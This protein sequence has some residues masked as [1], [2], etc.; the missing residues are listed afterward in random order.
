[1]RLPGLP[2]THGAEPVFYQTSAERLA[3]Y[4]DLG[5]APLKIGEEARVPLGDFSLEG[6]GRADLRQAYRRAQRD[7]ASFEVVPAGRGAELLPPRRPPPEARLA[8]R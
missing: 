6:G 5:L 8:S 1:G 2:D 4:I 3:L 7:G